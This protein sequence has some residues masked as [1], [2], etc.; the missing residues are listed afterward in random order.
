[1]HKYDGRLVHRA[2]DDEGE[3][4]VVDDAVYRSLHFG[5]LPKQSSMLLR[6]PYY[7]AL[8]YT[9]AM[10]CALLFQQKPRRILLIGLGGGSLAKFLLHHFP[11][12]RIDAVET[13]EAVLQVAQ[14]H[15]ALPRDER[16]Q[17]HFVD[18]GHFVRSQN[19]PE[20]A[21]YD[22]IF[23]DAFVDNGIARTV[24]GISFFEACRQL[25]SDSGI[26]S[27]NLWNGDFITAREM[28]EDVR[29]SFDG[30]TLQ[31]PVEGKDNTIALASNGEALKKKLKQL[32]PLAEAMAQRTGVEYPAFLKQLKK[33]NSWLKL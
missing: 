20:E 8:A 12:C 17:V 16:L 9:R 25:L 4:D 21:R 7:L 6:D 32:K 30:N 1:M 10:S 14:S 13:R 26:F 18:G 11:D 5:S 23:V 27:M 31:L 22:L 33:H 24:C 19:L 15:F 3:I 28:L 29:D 2:K